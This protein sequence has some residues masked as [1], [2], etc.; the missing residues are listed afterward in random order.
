MPLTLRM[1]EAT[2]YKNPRFL[3]A[4]AHYRLDGA[5]ST[6]PSRSSS[7]P[8]ISSPK[9]A[10]TSG[11][12]SRRIWGRYRRGR[13]DWEGFLTFSLKTSPYIKRNETQWVLRP[14]IHKPEGLAPTPVA[15]VFRWERPVS[16]P[17]LR[18]ADR[19]I[20]SRS[21][22]RACSSRDPCRRTKSE[23]AGFARACTPADESLHLSCR[24]FLFP[25]FVP[26]LAIDLVLC[27]VE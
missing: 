19:S 21:S 5:T 8:S 7:R 6:R 25:A 11:P 13:C 22:H 10:P 9:A 15:S 23:P 3:A 4:L 2:D 12:C 20:D 14:G 18:Q 24:F 16:P 1:N 27:V 17:G 26:D